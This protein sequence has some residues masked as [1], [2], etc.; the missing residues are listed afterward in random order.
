MNILNRSIFAKRAWL[1]A[2][3][4]LALMFVG[5]LIP[6]AAQGQKFSVVYTFTAKYDGATPQAPLIRDGKGNFYGTTEHGGAFGLGAIFELGPGGKEIPLHSFAGVDGLAPEGS[7]VR[8]ARGNLYG[9]TFYGGTP[10]GGSCGHG[11]GTVFKLDTQGKFT[12]LYAFSG[13]ADGGEPSGNLVFDEEGNL[14]GTAMMSGNASCDCGEVFKVDPTGKETV[15]YAF[16]GGA[17][18]SAPY[19]GGLVRDAAGN[20][21]GMTLFGG[22]TTACDPWGCGVVFKVDSSGNESVLHAFTGGTDGAAPWGTV[23]QDAFGNLYG[24]TTG[25]GS[26]GGGT[27]FMLD[28]T[29]KETVLYAFT[30]GAGGRAPYAGVSRDS[31][32]N[33][34][35]T[36][37]WGGDFSHECTFYGC[38]VVFRVDKNG[39]EHILYAFPDGADGD[40]YYYPTPGVIVDKKGNLYGPYP[41]GGK[42]Q[43]CLGECGFIYKIV[44]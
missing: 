13:K 28:T 22:D 5:P 7:L 43:R 16:N 1:A 26:S 36:T 42:A 15:V 23:S 27:V 32:G 44:P 39:K 19:G 14:Y 10:E 2:L 41:W 9:T 35:G 24:T 37:I 40:Q 4:L 11:C 31:D 8:D 20:L 21:Y 6:Y 12:M 33:L 38:G 3:P 30:R 25:G 29:G 17:D 18:G 34:Y